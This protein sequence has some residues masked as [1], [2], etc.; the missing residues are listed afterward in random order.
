MQLDNTYKIIHQL[1]EEEKIGLAYYEKNGIYLDYIYLSYLKSTDNPYDFQQLNTQNAEE[2]RTKLLNKLEK[3][4]SGVLAEQFFID[5]ATNT[6]IQHLPR[7]INI[8]AHR[9]DFFEIVCTLKGRC[10][11]RVEGKS[12][13]MEAGDITIIPPNV[14]HFLESEPDCLTFTIKTR[15]STFDSVFSVMMQSA[16]TLSAYF[17]QALYSK[18]YRNSLTFHCGQDA[19]LPELLLYMYAQQNEKK[20]YYNYVLDGLLATFFPYL[21]QN[22]EQCI[23]FS[24][25]ENVQ[26]ERII[27][28]E[29]YIR[30]HYRTTSLEDTAKKFYLSTAYLS[31]IIKKETGYTF[32][33]IL[34][35]IRM[36]N[37]AELLTDTQL[38]IEQI[39]ENVGYHDATQFIK[40]FKKYYGTTPLRFRSAYRTNR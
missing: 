17:A 34:R 5:K 39:C 19:F 26:N 6:E 11:H 23:E 29:N 7:Y 16:T 40:T 12:M 28:I 14:M 1:N 36:E 37:A 31:T 24:T 21:V 25:G 10:L 8:F 38:K 13:W 2:Y 27:Q 33:A 3:N 20:A 32:S 35:Q 15:K 18:H 9:H 22:Y 4:F 30:N